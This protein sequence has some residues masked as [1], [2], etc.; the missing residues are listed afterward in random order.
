MWR[1]ENSLICKVTAKVRSLFNLSKSLGRGEGKE[2][3]FFNPENSFVTRIRIIR[4][5]RPLAPP[6]YGCGFAVSTWGSHP[7]NHLH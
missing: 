5:E 6:A 4:K 2:G 3:I 7:G 1:L